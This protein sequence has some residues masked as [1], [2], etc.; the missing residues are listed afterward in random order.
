MG[1]R[2]GSQFVKFAIALILLGAVSCSRDNKGGDSAPVMIQGYTPAGE[3][4]NPLSVGQKAEF[5]Q[6]LSNLSRAPSV[7]V[8]YFS[9]K[10]QG[11]VPQ[12]SSD[13][14]SSQIYARME[15]GNCIVEMKPEVINGST[16]KPQDGKPMEFSLNVAGPACP[17]S[18]ALRLN[19]TV[20]QASAQSGS[21]NMGLD[22]HYSISDPQLSALNDISKFDLVGGGMMSATGSEH[23]ASVNVDM[24]VSGSATSLSRGVIGM[25]LRIYGGLAYSKQGSSGQIGLSILF[26]Q[27]GYKVLLQQIANVSSTDGLVDKYYL[28]GEEISKYDFNQLLS[29]VGFGSG[30]AHNLES[31][32]NKFK[33][34]LQ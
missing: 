24:S 5:K 34:F 22:M 3:R 7:A 10:K 31:A 25:S 17:I 32:K 12:N 27:S 2:F 13:Q 21:M 30:A 11:R 15:Q 9:D 18:S 29:S 26:A 16:P 28:N 14:T 19:M 4:V 23:S 1:L 33:S 20:Q 6:T 8:K